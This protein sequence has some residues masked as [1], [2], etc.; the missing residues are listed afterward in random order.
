MDIP[1][2][3]HF[4]GAGAVAQSPIFKL[5]SYLSRHFL[6]CVHE[7]VFVPFHIKER[8]TVVL[9]TCGVWATHF[10]SRTFGLERIMTTSNS[11]PTCTH[12][13]LSVHEIFITSPCSLFSSLPP[14][15]RIASPCKP[16]TWHVLLLFN[17]DM[18]EETCL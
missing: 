17:K 8:D 6:Q 18:S 11:T 4:L 1:N 9:S 15:V 13:F 14:T 7:W 5:L 12:I 16:L 3:I 2:S 10:E